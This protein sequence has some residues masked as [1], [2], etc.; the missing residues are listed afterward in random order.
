MHRIILVFRDGKKRLQ[1]LRYFSSPIATAG[2]ISSTCVCYFSALLSVTFTGILL[3]FF[4]S[5]S[6]HS[7][8]LSRSGLLPSVEVQNQLGWMRNSQKI[9]WLGCHLESVQELK[10]M[11]VEAVDEGVSLFLFLQDFSSW[12]LLSDSPL[13]VFGIISHVQ[14]V[15]QNIFLDGGFRWGFTCFLCV[16]GKVFIVV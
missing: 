4:P 14:V 6:S 9:Q 5:A 16:Y 12:T 11:Q 7:K 10:M 8:C 3:P 15:K 13:Y 2:T 1:F